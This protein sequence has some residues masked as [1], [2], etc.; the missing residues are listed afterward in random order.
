LQELISGQDIP[1]PFDVHELCARVSKRR[2]RPIRLRPLTQAGLPCGMYVA[3]PDEDH[4]FYSSQTPLL[5]QEQIILHELGHMLCGHQATSLGVLTKETISVLLPDLDPDMVDMF[6]GRTRRNYS[7][8]DEREAEIIA[9]LILQQAKSAP[10][11]PV[12]AVRSAVAERIEHS[13]D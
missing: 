9:S 11:A 1:V 2:G 6:L 5:H 8:P 12:P 4:I 3:L 7:S 10:S 13:L